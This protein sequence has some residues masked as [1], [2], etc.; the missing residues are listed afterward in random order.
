[1][2]HKNIITIGLELASD[3]VHSEDL[4]SKISLLDWDIILIKPVIDQFEADRTF[5]GKPAFDEGDSFQLKECAEHWRREIKDAIDAGKMVVVFLPPY[6]EVYIDSGDRTY[7]GTG[8]NQKT[9]I[10]V[11]KFS[12]YEF[13]PATLGPVAKLGRS[14]KL[15]PQGSEYLASYWSDFESSSTYNVIL[16]QPGLT[17]AMTTRSG[18][19]A[20]GCI[21]RSKINSGTIVLVPDIEF[22]HESFLGDDDHWTPAA[23]QFASRMIASMVSL[24]KSLHSQ[25]ERSAEPGWVAERKYMMPAE[26]ALKVR[27]LEAEQLVEEA[28]R[29]KEDAIEALQALGGIRSLLFEKGK[30]LENSIIDAL[31]IMGF[32]AE[33]FQDAESEFDVV[34]HSSEGRFIGEAEGKDNKAV[35]IEKLRQLTMNIH[36]DLMRDDVSE[37]AK[38]VLFGNGYRLAP[39]EDRQD[40]FTTKC[41]S[42]A[43]SSGAALVFTPDL[44]TVVQYLSGANNEEYAQECRQAILTQSGR[45]KFPM[46]PESLNQALASKIELA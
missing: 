31:R 25:G 35:N 12:N 19:K 14:I 29:Q 43:S 6:E 20:V 37:P 33:P 40:P 16:T 4:N 39:L 22:Y 11:N 13:L 38:A 1:M 15:T 26:P 27:L 28:Q 3:T 24:E 32:S 17:T 5:Q 9:T 7:S 10:K 34:F 23:E 46:P 36:E 44:L 45:V 21:I 18:D 42:A 2:A 8:K 41:H 30:P